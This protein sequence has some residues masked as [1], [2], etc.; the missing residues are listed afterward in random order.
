MSLITWRDTE[1]VEEEGAIRFRGQ[2]I[3]IRKEHIDRWREDR[4]GRFQLDP[5]GSDQEA[6]ELGKFFPSL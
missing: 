5:V 3:L 1:F 6:A 2:L 4:D